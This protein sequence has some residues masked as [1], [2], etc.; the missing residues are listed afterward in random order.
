M[1]PRDR[2]GARDAGCVTCQWCRFRITGSQ[3]FEKADQLLF[4][5]LGQPLKVPDY[6]F[7]LALVPFDGIVQSQ[8][9]QVMHDSGAHPQAPERL[10]TQL[11]R[12]I[13]RPRLYDAIACLN[14]MQQEVTVWMNDFVA[15]CLGHH[16]RS[17]VYGGP[18]G[19]GAARRDQAEWRS[20]TALKIARR[21]TRGRGPRAA[22]ARRE[23]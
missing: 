14:V 3:S 6:L 13:L 4:F 22:A 17:A 8:R 2:A 9:S 5:S 19:G 20:P 15:Q 18:P 11:V 23:R 16:E 1:A 7:R 12:G 10:C 21:H